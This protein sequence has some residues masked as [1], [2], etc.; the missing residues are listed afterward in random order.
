MAQQSRSGDTNSQVGVSAAARA[1]D[2]SRPADDDLAAAEETVQVSYRP[3][4]RSGSQPRSSRRGGSS[5]VS[6]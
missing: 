2:V 6:S 4:A 3:T 1:R 5:P